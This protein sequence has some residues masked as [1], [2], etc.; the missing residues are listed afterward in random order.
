MLE[1]RIIDLEQRLQRVIMRGIVAHINDN[2]SYTVGVQTDYNDTLYLTQVLYMPFVTDI[3]FQIPKH[4]PEDI[5]AD[6]ALA[7]P[8]PPADYLP[9][10]HDPN[11]PETYPDTYATR[12]TEEYPLSIPTSSSAPGPHTHVVPIPETIRQHY[13]N[14]PMPNT[15]REHAEVTVVFPIPKVDD[16]VWIWSPNGNPQDE[17]IIVGKFVERADVNGIKHRVEHIIVETEI[18]EDIF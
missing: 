6:S 18:L 5:P 2:G 1:Q 15:I 7:G 10:Y 9:A 14:V 12:D 3:I 17:A 13:H 8:L 16:R 4:F 11:E